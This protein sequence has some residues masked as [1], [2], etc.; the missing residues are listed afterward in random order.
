MIIER[1]AMSEWLHPP[2]TLKGFDQLEEIMKEEE[3]C[4][5]RTPMIYIW[6]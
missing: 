1:N 2:E 5:A 4:G 3:K 6:R